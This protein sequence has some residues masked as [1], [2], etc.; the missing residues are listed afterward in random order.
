MTAPPRPDVDL[1]L[2]FIAL[3]ASWMRIKAYIEALERY[4][5]QLEAQVQDPEPPEPMYNEGWD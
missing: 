4:I 1:Q 3:P 2:L 5:E